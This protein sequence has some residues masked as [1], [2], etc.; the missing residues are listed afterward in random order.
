[1]KLDYDQRRVYVASRITNELNAVGLTC[2]VHPD[3]SD[4]TAAHPVGGLLYPWKMRFVITFPDG[5]TKAPQDIISLN[6]TD[7]DLEWSIKATTP[8]IVEYV[9]W[10]LL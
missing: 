2:V 9:K 7:E 8:S 1:M 5:T 6:Q 3:P 4:T 10:H